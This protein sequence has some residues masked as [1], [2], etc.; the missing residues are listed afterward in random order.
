MTCGVGRGCPSKGV[1]CGT[2]RDN[3][4]TL[5]TKLKGAN[6]MYYGG[7][8]LG[9]ACGVVQMVC[10]GIGCGTVVAQHGMTLKSH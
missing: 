10:R 4:M 7:S 8:T 3:S 2:I 9:I 6:C 1:I 5:A